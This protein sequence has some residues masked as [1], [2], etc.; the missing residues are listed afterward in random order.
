[1]ISKEVSSKFILLFVITGQLSVCHG[2]CKLHDASWEASKGPT[3][4]QP[5]K[6]EPTKVKIDWGNVIKNAR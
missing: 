1:M 2:A 5:S 3:I 4:S 6:N